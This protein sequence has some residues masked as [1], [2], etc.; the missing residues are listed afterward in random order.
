MR[1]SSPPAETGAPTLSLLSSSTSMH[2]N[3]GRHV[4]LAAQDGRAG[5]IGAQH[6][7]E[8]TGR[9]RQPV[10]LVTSRSCVL[11]VEVNGTIGARYKGRSVADAVAVDWVVH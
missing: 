10:R 8:V 11:D 1:S 7:H 3:D 5:L 4:V 2:L 6:Q 9:C